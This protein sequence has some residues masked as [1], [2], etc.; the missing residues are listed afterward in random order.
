MNKSYILLRMYDQ[1]RTGK[2]VEIAACCQ[3]YD[4]SISTFRRY[5][6]F[7]RGYFNEFYG[8]EIVYLPQTAEYVLITD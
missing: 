7:L 1:F 5:I 8:R 6:A 4:I 3:E 2:K